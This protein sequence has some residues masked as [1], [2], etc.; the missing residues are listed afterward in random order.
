MP[1]VGGLEDFMKKFE[2]VVAGVIAGCFSTRE[3]AEQAKKFYLICNPV[4]CV[5]IRE[6]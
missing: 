6:K 5:W 4:D 3:E 2:V 1:S